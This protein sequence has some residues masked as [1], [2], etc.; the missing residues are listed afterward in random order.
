MISVIVICRLETSFDFEGVRTVTESGCEKN[1]ICRCRQ[2]ND[3]ILQCWF[4][5]QNR[6][7]VMRYASNSEV[8]WRMGVLKD[9]FYASID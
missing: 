2:A 4:R 7:R 8:M 5:T 1:N 9:E 3:M 6:S